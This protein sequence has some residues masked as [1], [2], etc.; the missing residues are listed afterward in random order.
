MTADDAWIGALEQE[1]RW[2]RINVSISKVL[3]EGNRDS[4]C[5]ITVVFSSSKLVSMRSE[6]RD[7]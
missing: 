5:A 7:R 3:A 6:G 1:A 4:T 2:S